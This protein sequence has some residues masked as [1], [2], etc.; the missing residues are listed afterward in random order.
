MSA[1]ADATFPIILHSKPVQVM[2]ASDP[3]PERKEGAS[4]REGTLAVSSKLVRAEVP[5]SRHGRGNR[6]GSDIV[7]PKD[8]N[9]TNSN[10]TY[11]NRGGIAARLGDPFKGRELVAYDDIL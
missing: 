9:N 4:K 8:D 3:L 5:L 7:N 10:N 11:K 6:L 2:W 1:S